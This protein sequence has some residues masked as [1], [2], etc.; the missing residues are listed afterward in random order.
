MSLSQ[1]MVLPEFRFFSASIQTA[2]KTCNSRPVV[3][4]FFFGEQFMS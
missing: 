2:F 3:F 1:N 4:G